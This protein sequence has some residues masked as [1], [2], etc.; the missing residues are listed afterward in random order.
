MP[1]SKPKT[2]AEFISEQI[3][4]SAKTQFEISREAGFETPN[5]ITMLKQG[6][7]KIPIN[8]VYSL[9]VAL[10]IKPRHL[11]RMVLEEYLPE[12]LLAIEA[13]WGELLLSPDEEGIVLT[14]REMRLQ[15]SDVFRQG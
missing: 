1:N 10:D 7:T 11:L 9:A 3:D 15:E 5:L 6:K 4:K 14:Y 13:S 2:V 12:T 8:R